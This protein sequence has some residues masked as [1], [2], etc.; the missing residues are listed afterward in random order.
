MNGLIKRCWCA[1]QKLLIRA[2][3]S[4]RLLKFFSNWRNV[5]KYKIKS[6]GRKTVLDT[7]DSV[8]I[9][10]YPCNPCSA[11][12]YTAPSIFQFLGNLPTRK[13]YSVFHSVLQY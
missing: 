11:E 4:W 13:K 7:Y 12:Y 10:K 8:T 6:N 3:D 2:Y 1:V 9:E 5:D